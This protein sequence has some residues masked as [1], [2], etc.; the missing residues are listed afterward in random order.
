VNKS[1]TV[2]WK[3]SRCLLL[4]LGLGLAQAGAFASDAQD[5]RPRFDQ[6]MSAYAD[7]HYVEAARRL[8]GAVSGGDV[9]AS[10]VLG[11]MN[12][13]GATL[14]GAGPW[15]K[16]L[17]WALLRQAARQGS[18][19]AAALTNGQGRNAAIAQSAATQTAAR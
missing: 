4:A 19:M 14:Y 5:A 3:P 13:Y 15:D 8:N 6:A 12:L 16:A 9:R 17:G 2:R 18:E 1:L 11:L 10:E 7:G